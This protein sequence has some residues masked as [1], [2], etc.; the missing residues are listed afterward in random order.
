MLNQLDFECNSHE[1][2]RLHKAYPMHT[3]KIVSGREKHELLKEVL[4]NTLAE[5]LARKLSIQESVSI[6]SW[7]VSSHY[8][9]GH[10]H[11]HRCPICSEVLVEVQKQ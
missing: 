1:Q 7:A 2:K 5:L 11:R 6:L 9:H 8:P 3:K 4:K 10:R